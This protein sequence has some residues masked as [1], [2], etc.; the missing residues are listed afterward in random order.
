MPLSFRLPPSST[1]GK[2]GKRRR[3]GAARNNFP[4]LTR[5]DFP[6]AKKKKRTL[7]YCWM[8]LESTGVSNK[9]ENF[10]LSFLSPLAFKKDIA[11]GIFSGD[12]WKVCIEKRRKRERRN[13]YRKMPK[14]KPVQL[15]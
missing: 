4:H 15:D 3:R 1:W 14:K 11:A 12:G 5:S 2:G 13:L 7:Q 9:R 6:D 10:P 8:K